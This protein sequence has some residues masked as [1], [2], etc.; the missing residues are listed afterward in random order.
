MDVKQVLKEMIENPSVSGFE[1]SMA[2]RIEAYLKDIT[3]NIKRD[4]LGNLIA[5]KKGT[6][7]NPIKIMLAAHM[8]EI[9]LMVKDIDKNGFIKVTNIGGVDQRTLL[10]QEVIIHGKKD[11]FGV[12]ATKAPHLQTPEER[13]SAVAIEDLLID[14]GLTKEEA[15]QFISI[16][17]PI[18][19]NRQMIPLLGDTIAGKAL[20]DKAGIA[21]MIECFRELK[22]INHQCDVFGVAT[23][24]EEVGT[25]GAIVSTFGISP[26]IG[27]AVDVGFGK[28]PELSKDDTLELGKGPGITLGAN[29]H[30]KIHKR[31]KEIAK[32]YNIPFQIELSPGNS[33]TD[34]QSMQITQSGVATGVLS[35]PLRYMHTSVETINLQDIK[36]T[37]RLLAY[38]IASLDDEDLEGFLCF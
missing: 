10:A 28:T 30:P 12:I 29:I 33:G 31:F 8:D 11:L 35:I 4:K 23:V 6:A 9:G 7:K 20:D 27:I 26:H 21:A 24:Q 13:K 25:R 36:N 15:E 22:K 38:F 32:E 37:G 17:D 14:I 18:T 16:G 34:A 1:S 3:D 5:Y 2:N 19:I